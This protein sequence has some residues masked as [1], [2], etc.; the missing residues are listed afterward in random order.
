MDACI[1]YEY[2][3]QQKRP[4]NISFNLYFT[5]T[6]LIKFRLTLTK[7][8]VPASA[9]LKRP[10]LDSSQPLTVFSTRVFPPLRPHFLKGQ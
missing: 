4:K 3:Y 7:R 9:G 2:I 5:H 1:D 8:L 10:T 6:V